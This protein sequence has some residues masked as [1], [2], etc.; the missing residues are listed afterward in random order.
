M[1]DAAVNGFLRKLDKMTVVV[2]GPLC[3]RFNRRLGEGVSHEGKRRVVREKNTRQR[4]SSLPVLAGED[5]LKI[6]DNR[7][8]VFLYGVPE[9]GKVNSE[10]LVG[11]NIPHP[12][13]FSPWDTRM[14]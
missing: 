7:R 3:Q 5:V 9:N 4:T 12:P 2:S 1:Q 8:K 14:P 13:H 10:I 11:Q 6:L